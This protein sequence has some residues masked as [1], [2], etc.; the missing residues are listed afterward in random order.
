MIGGSGLDGVRVC[1]IVRMT[2]CLEI[3]LVDWFVP[4]VFVRGSF[5]C[6]E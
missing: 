6:W 2:D 5:A 4:F 3:E 1:P